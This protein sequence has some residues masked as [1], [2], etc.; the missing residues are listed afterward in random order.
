MIATKV[1]C[2]QELKQCKS[3]L[4]VHAR[5]MQHAAKLHGV[6]RTK[7][8]IPNSL[9]QVLMLLGPARIGKSHLLKDLEAEFGRI[10]VTP[11]GR[12]KKLL[13][14]RVPEGGGAIATMT[15][16]LRCL[17]EPYK[18]TKSDELMARVQK[19]L[20]AL[21]V[22][23]VILDDVHH[24]ADEGRK[25][26]VRAG[27]DILKGLIELNPEVTMIFA[28]IPLASRLRE[29]NPQVRGRCDAP[30]YYLPYC[31]DDVEQRNDFI[32]AVFPVYNVVSQAMEFEELEANRFISGMY[33]LG[34]GCFGFVMKFMEAIINILE[35][36]EDGGLLTK[37]DLAEAFRRKARDT[38]YIVNPFENFDTVTEPMLIEAWKQVMTEEGL[39]RFITAGTLVGAKI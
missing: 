7:I 30:D 1:D 21:G 4:I 18:T 38:T 23:V 37:S 26:S 39:A 5:H 15:E 32:S 22:Q 14:V 10:E 29:E 2:L 3:E 36:K 31:W 8:L 24:F 20:Q 28:G 13:Y 16:I 11:T 9:P 25:A 35:Q 19:R 33:L 17:G 12:Q 27:S 6:V 34:G